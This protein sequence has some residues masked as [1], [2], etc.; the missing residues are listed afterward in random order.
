MILD[1]Q[2]LLAADRLA[3]VIQKRE[4]EDQK[5]HTKT[6]SEQVETAQGL[7]RDQPVLQSLDSVISGEAMG[8]AEK[9]GASTKKPIELPLEKEITGEAGSGEQRAGSPKIL[10]ADGEVEPQADW[11]FQHR[12]AKTA[13]GG[14]VLTST[15]FVQLIPDRGG[16][17]PVGA[18]F[19]SRTGEH[20]VMKVRHVFWQFVHQGMSEVDGAPVVCCRASQDSRGA[21]TSGAVRETQGPVVGE[22]G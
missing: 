4:C 13:E 1:P 15:T 3:D 22:M 7:H 19:V 5:L 14:H 9:P 18:E 11:D 17:S 8:I 21:R 2:I 10:P 6:S 20:F 16:G 12:L